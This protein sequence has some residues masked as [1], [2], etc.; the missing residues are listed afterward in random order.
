MTTVLD[1][2][3][4]SFPTP[5]ARRLDRSGRAGRPKAWRDPRF[6][7]GIVLVAASAALGAWAVRSAASTQEIYAVAADVA[8]GT[9]LSAEGVLTV[10]SSHPG[11]GSYVLAGELPEHAV[12]TRPLSAGELLPTAAVGQ[13]TEQDLRP[14]VVPVSTGL[15]GGVGVGSGV[16]LWLLPRAGAAL[17]AKGEQAQTRLVAASLVVSAVGEQ[18]RTLVGDSQER[19]VEVLV[20]AAALPEVLA[21]LGA[22]GSLVLVP[23][24]AG[25]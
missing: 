1:D 3:P 2:S 11:T 24:G 20:P 14:V 17:A 12:A 25:A 21:A 13:H 10:V 23:A 5:P 19:D 15:P 4:A 8:P 18:E 22:E 9:D 7:I 6:V 16:D